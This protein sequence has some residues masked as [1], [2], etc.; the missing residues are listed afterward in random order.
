MS[1][2]LSRSSFAPHEGSTIAVFVDEDSV[3]DLEINSVEDHSNE[4]VDSFSILLKSA[5]DVSVPDGTYKFQH[6]GIGNFDMFI[7]EVNQPTAV[8]KHL[9][10]V[11]SRL[12]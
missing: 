3:I 10:A 6:S 2:E 5:P 7:S 9:E 12:K 11:F 8:T 4:K 1:S